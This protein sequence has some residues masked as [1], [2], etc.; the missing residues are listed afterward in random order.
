MVHE[1]YPDHNKRLSGDD[2]GVER[3]KCRL[4]PSRT[5]GIH[6]AEHLAAQIRRAAALDDVHINGCDTLSLAVKRHL[7]DLIGQ[8]VKRES[9]ADRHGSSRFGRNADPCLAETLGDPVCKL[10]FGHLCALADDSFAEELLERLPSAVHVLFEEQK[11]R[12]IRNIADQIDELIGSIAG[13]QAG[14]TD[15]DKFLL[16]QP[17]W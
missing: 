17:W 15:D 6:Y 13:E 1:C 11:Y 8:R 5:A 4:C 2:Q 9:A 7:L 16:G 14:L 10:F 3:I 12:R